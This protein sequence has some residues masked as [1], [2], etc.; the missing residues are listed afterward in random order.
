MPFIENVFREVQAQLVYLGR[1]RWG[2]LTLRDRPVYVGASIDKQG[3]F[4]ERKGTRSAC[5]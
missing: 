1:K 5:F 4:D 3:S 2:Y